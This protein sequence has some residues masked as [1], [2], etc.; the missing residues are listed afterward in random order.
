MGAAAFTDATKSS[1]M[2]LSPSLAARIMCR[3]HITQLHKT[4]LPDVCWCV[5][6]THGVCVCVCVS[7]ALCVHES[8]CVN[9][10]VCVYVY[11]VNT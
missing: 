10:C 9:V 6:Y 2:V 3:I 1:K 5:L 8:E 4:A 7:L 11:T